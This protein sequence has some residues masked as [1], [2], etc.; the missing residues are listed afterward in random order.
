MENCVQP[1]FVAA[2]GF[3]AFAHFQADLPRVKDFDTQKYAGTGYHLAVGPVYRPIP[4]LG[5]YAGL[6]FGAYG[7]RNLMNPGVP[8]LGWDYEAGLMG[9]Y[10]NVMLSVGFFSARTADGQHSTTLLLGL[11]GYLKRYHDARFGYC[12]S[13]SRR[14]WSVSYVARPAVNGKGV[15]FGDLGKEKARAYLKALYI[16]SEVAQKDQV[17]RNIDASGGILFTPVNGLIDACVGVGAEVNLVGLDN[18][19]L[20][21]GAEV[22]VVLNLWRFPITIM[23]HESDL[24]HESRHPYVDFGIGFHFGEFKRS[25]YK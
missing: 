13:D 7:G 24:F 17:A 15:M 4:Y 9:M 19:F 18:K 8:L 3:G 5:L 2:N 21:V 6:G 23:L 20:G 11:G 14:W 22:G 25:S 10:R 1:G 16:Q 12:A